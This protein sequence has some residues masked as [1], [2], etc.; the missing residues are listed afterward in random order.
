[1]ILTRVAAIAAVAALLL[2]ATLA[3]KVARVSAGSTQIDNL[4][5]SMSTQ[6]KVGQLFMVSFYGDE[7]AD[8]DAAPVRKNRSRHGVDNAAD[9]VARY[10]VGG[11]IYFGWAG[12]LVSTKQ[13]ARLSNG[14]Q[15]A[16]AATTHGIPLLISTDQEGG[17]VARLAPPAPRFPGNMALG[18]SRRTDLARAAAN[19]MGEELRAVGINEDLAPVADVNVNPANPVIGLRSFGSDPTL[20]ADMTAAQVRGYELDAGIAATAKHFPGHGDTNI[21]SHSGLPIINHSLAKWYEL[22]A[23]P[24]EAAISAGV[25][26]IMSAHISVPALDPTG[27]PATLSPHILTDLLRGELGFDGV[28]MTDSLGM[29]ALRKTYTDARVPVL[30]ILAG[31]DILLNPPKLPVAFNAVVDSVQSGEISV[32]R[33]NAS[34]RRI[35]ELKQSLG[36]FDSSRVGVKAAAR[37]V[38]SAAHLALERDVARASVTLVANDGGALPLHPAA[39][40]SALLVGP[41]GPPLDVLAAALGKRGLATEK[42]VTGAHPTDSA[43]VGA[44]VR[45]ASHDY[46]IAL[47]QNAD[48][49]LKQRDLVDALAGTGTPLVTASVGRPYEI[50]YYESDAHFCLYSASNASI[51]A[52]AAALVGELNPAARLPVAIPTAADPDT[53]LYDY[54]HGL[55][56][57]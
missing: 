21:D 23:P 18:A 1:V 45:A 56:Y 57:P 40:E 16:A 26:V 32:A 5:A 12:N 9:L 4:I 55:S 33:L 35:L 17:A 53:A 49:N 27:R 36:L 54:G 2:V 29:G 31:A 41:A 38:G 34:V 28:V 7:A 13:V 46:V 8:T 20:V 30:A 47:T 43:I 19:A 6:E 25:D 48:T 50:A 11:V 10:H 37:V 51:R 24:F 39:G 3:V 52:L 14:I 22:D 44:A 15:D 42:R